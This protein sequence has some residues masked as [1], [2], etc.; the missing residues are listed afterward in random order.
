MSY[1][2]GKII[3][4][5]HDGLT[6]QKVDSELPPYSHLLVNSRSILPRLLLVTRD[7]NGI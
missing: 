2:I 5:R 3:A 7:S 1:Q 6:L 4:F